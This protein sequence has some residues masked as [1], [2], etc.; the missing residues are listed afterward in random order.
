MEEDDEIEQYI[1]GKARVVDRLNKED[2]YRIKCS[3]N[4]Y[5]RIWSKC[6]VNLLLANKL[7]VGDIISMYLDYCEGNKSGILELDLLPKN[8]RRNRRLGAKYLEVL[9]Y[10]TF[11]RDINYEIKRKS[12]PIMERIGDPLYS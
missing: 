11:K 1:L 4:H 8:L 6:F 3:G 7:Q 9:I 2:L 12:I 5:L 10:V